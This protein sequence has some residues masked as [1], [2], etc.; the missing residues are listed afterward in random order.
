MFENMVLRR[1]FEHKRNEGTGEWKENDIMRS[2]MICTAHQILFV[3]SNQEEWVGGVFIIYGEKKVAYRILMEK[4]ERKRPL[5][6]P[7]LRWEDNIKMDIKEVGWEA[8]TGLIWL[9]VWRGDV[10]LYNAVM[11]FR[12]L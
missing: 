3:C 2:L 8:W 6:R 7:R 11:N 10:L 9:S 4:T 12:V 1:I 5:G